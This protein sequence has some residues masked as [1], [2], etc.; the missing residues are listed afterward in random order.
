MKLII[1]YISEPKLSVSRLFVR[2]LALLVYVYNETENCWNKQHEMISKIYFV[3]N[4]PIARYESR[5]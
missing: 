3:A 4:V 2:S 5:P 1:E